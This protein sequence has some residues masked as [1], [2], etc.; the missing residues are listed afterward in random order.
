VRRFRSLLRS[1]AHL[2]G[3]SMSSFME[4]PQR[5]ANVSVLPVLVVA[6]LC[7]ALGVSCKC[8]RSTPDRSPGNGQNGAQ[9]PL[10]LHDADGLDAGDDGSVPHDGATPHAI[11]PWPDPLQ[12]GSGEADLDGDGAL[13]CWRLSY[14]GGNAYG[15][16]TMSVRAPCG[17]P[18]LDIRI[19]G[20]FGEFVSI[21]P[22]PVELSRRTALLHGL[23]EHWFQDARRDLGDIDGSLAW[24][25]DQYLAAAPRVRQGGWSVEVPYS[26]RWMSGSPGLPRRQVVLLLA[27]AEQEMGRR[28]AKKL[29]IDDEPVRPGPFLLVYDAHN[30]HEMRSGETRGDLTVYSTDHAIAVA[31]PTEN[32]WSWVFVSTDQYRLRKASIRRVETNGAF[33]A[34]EIADPTS[35][36][37]RLVVAEPSTGRWMWRI[38]A[39]AWRLD[40]SGLAIGRRSFS[41]SQLEAALE[42]SIR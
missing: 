41:N 37:S 18:R 28:L 15:W 3:L 11:A 21:A 6:C 26:P 33:V 24:L 34:G 39:G 30:H 8:R 5:V 20:S 32:T 27:P 9:A 36:A 42:Q 12:E 40:E 7:A 35:S 31:R 16:W 22:L 1:D 4:R 23:I 17:S 10:P 2:V 19:G 13:D 14:D 29:S 25:L 38:P